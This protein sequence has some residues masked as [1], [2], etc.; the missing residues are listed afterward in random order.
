MFSFL[1]GASLAASLFILA[2]SLYY[3]SLTFVWKE[4]SMQVTLDD[5]IRLITSPINILDIRLEG[6]FVFTLLNNLLYNTNVNNLALHGLHPRYTHFLVNFPVL[7]GPLALTSLYTIWTTS[8]KIRHEPNSY[9]Y[10]TMVGIVFTSM[11]GLSLI[12][13]Q[14]ARFLVP[15]LVPL[16][17]IYTWDQ[18]ANIGSV[19]FLLLWIGFNLVASFVFGNL[20]Q[21]GVV[22][23]MSF[24]QRQTMG[25]NGCQLLSYG[26]ITC[27]II[28]VDGPS[29]VSIEDVAGNQTLLYD[30]LKKRQGIIYR[31]HDKERLQIE[32]SPSKINEGTYER[33]LLIVPNVTPLPDIP[34]Q[35]Y[36][37]IS[38]YEPHVNFD[39]IGEMFKIAKKYDSPINLASLNIF[40]ILSD[41]SA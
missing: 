12:P 25:I 28:P 15:M 13:H 21:A 26:D 35:K 29:Q 1:F 39:D 6:N 38:N 32:F 3:G 41:N 5:A 16:V 9:L 30:T 17:M 8:K 22:P 34:G 23:T 20:H 18:D 24:V 31:K 4:S 7:Y 10:Y 19:L 11:I 33:T 2:D 37:L 14:E 36:M 27:D 40:V